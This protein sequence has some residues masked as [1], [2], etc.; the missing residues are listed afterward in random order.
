[1]NA[2]FTPTTSDRLLG[3]LIITG[4]MLLLTAIPLGVVISLQEHYKSHSDWRWAI[5]QGVVLTVATA[6][7]V[8]LFTGA[9][10][11][12]VQRRRRAHERRR[13]NEA[14]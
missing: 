10:E 8:G 9:G 5:T 14:A 13:H 12:I 4:F 1:M 2:S 6:I 11:F 3:L 7:V